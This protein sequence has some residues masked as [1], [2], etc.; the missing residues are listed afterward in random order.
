MSISEN[1]GRAPS[2]QELLEWMKIKPRTYGWD[3][4]LCYDRTVLNQSLWRD[5]MERSD[6]HPFAAP[7]SDRVIITENS[8]WEFLYSVKLGAPQL[9][10]EQSSI[11]SPRVT[12]NARAW[13]GRQLTVTAVQGG[14][15]HITSIAEYS[16]LQGPRLVADAFIDDEDGA[17]SAARQVRM[18]LS[19]AEKCQFSFPGSYQQQVKGGTAFHDL[20]KALPETSHHCLLNVL[21]EWDDGAMVPETVRPRPLPVLDAEDNPTGDGAVVVMV[22]CTG[23]DVGGHPDVDGDWK[24]PIPQGY[25][26]A[27]WIGGHRLMKGIVESSI[28]GA[29]TGAEFSYDNSNDPTVLTVTKG[30]LLPLVVEGSTQPFSA[31]TYSVEVPLAANVSSTAFLDVARGDEGLTLNWKTSSFTN[32]Q[33]PVLQSQG[34]DGA[35]ALD[36]AWRIRATYAFARQEDGTLG[37]R[38]VGQATRWVRPV[39]R[40]AGALDPLHY[41]HF[42]AMAEEIADGLAAVVDRTVARMLGGS[43]LGEVDRLRYEGLQ[44]PGGAGLAMT[45]VH[46]PRD[47]VLLGTLGPRPGKFLVTPPQARMLAGSTLQLETEPSQ[48]GLEWTVE[49][50]EDFQGDAGTISA[51]GLY[52]APASAAIEGRFVLVR[53]TASTATHASSTWVAVL[54]E[55]LSVNPIVAVVTTP[56]GTVRLSAGSLDEEELDWSLKS[57]TGAALELPHPDELALFEPGD[58]VYHRGSGSTGNYFS[59]DEVTARTS[60]GNTRATPILVMEKDRA[61]TIRIRDEGSLP[62]GQ[63]QL[64]FFGSKPDP[65]PDVVWTLWAGGGSIADTGL[66]TYDPDAMPPFA[67]ITAQY[68]SDLV[69]MGN[70]LVLPFPMVDLN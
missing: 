26:A 69:D 67:L 45:S 65:L 40:Q 41:E 18:D 57:E 34:P 21:G 39:Y 70:F 3:A 64:D 37:L 12:M 48:A 31:L 61:G 50:L 32:A 29:S 27:L 30:T 42:P 16:P 2:E 46:L 51:T 60:D 14:A 33:A 62:A 8:V 20:I 11:N 43:E 68:E 17:A 22:A 63:I 15:R 54:T 7:F 49:L 66:Y 59:M 55:A 58:R 53:V 52:T 25:H 13:S 23:S 10:F 28:R 19:M 38:P 36:S 56:T 1:T 44:C 47:L 9:S 5:Y 4:W 35:T 24:Y 6:I